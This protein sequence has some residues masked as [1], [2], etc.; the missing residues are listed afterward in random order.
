MD[1]L[2]LRPLDR[3]HHRLRL[4][5]CWRLHRYP[6]HAQLRRGQL[7]DVQRERPR[8]RERRAERTRWCVPAVYKSDVFYLGIRMGG[9]VG[10][11]LEPIICADSDLVVVQGREVAAKKSLG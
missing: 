6:R 7:P 10:G 4:L 8:R 5:G 3:P 11:V 9:Y 1:I 2:P